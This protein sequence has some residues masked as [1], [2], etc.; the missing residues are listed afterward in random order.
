MGMFG[1]EKRVLMATADVWHKRLGHASDDKLTQIE[2]LKS[3]SFNKMCDSC[4]RAKH[5]RLPIQNSEIK[6]ND[7]FELLHCDVWGKYR[8]A[9]LSGPITS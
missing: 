8:Y 2:F 3:I 4:S 9:S 5:T 6:T 7:C 1:T